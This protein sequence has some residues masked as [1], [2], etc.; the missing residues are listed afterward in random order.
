MKKLIVIFSIT[1]IFL[2]CERALIEPDLGSADAL[3]NF[4]YLWNEV[5]KKYSYFEEKDVDWDEVKD[6]YRPMLSPSSTEQELFEV[7]GNMLNELRD[8]HT[9]LFSPFNLSRYDVAVNSPDNQDQRTIREFYVPD[10][11]VTGPFIHGFLANE[12]IGYIAYQSF[13]EPFNDDQLDV[14]LNRY[15]N[16]KGLIIDVRANGGGNPLL[17]PKI[18]DRKSVV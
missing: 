4:D 15:Q 18:L 1:F 11:W 17:A 5:D 16:T 8:D 13:G 3:T 6:I 7:L 2:S 14:I 9:N 10:G 12:E